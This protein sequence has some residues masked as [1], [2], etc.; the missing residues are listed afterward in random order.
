MDAP[1]VGQTVAQSK[2]WITLTVVL[3]AFLLG[4]CRPGSQPV[5][6]S[7][8]PTPTPEPRP[9]SF[10]ADELPHDVLTEWWYYTGHLKGP[11]GRA[12]GFEFVI[13]QSQRRS[14]V[15]YA[16]H[17]AITDH[18]GP[19]F[20]YAEAVSQGKQA[21]KAQLELTVGPWRLSGSQGRYS[22]EAVMQDYAVRLTT[23]PQKPPALHMGGIIDYGPAGFSY[24]YSYTRLSVSGIMVEGGRPISVR[25]TAWMDHQWGNFIPLAGGGW[26]WFA[27]QLDTGED[28]MVYVLRDPSGRPLGGYGTFIDTAGTVRSTDPRHL[29]VAPLSQWTSPRT[30]ITYPMGW[31]LNVPELDLELQLRP[32]LADQ[33]LD[34][35]KSTGVIYW[36]GEV[37]VEGLKGSVPVRGE[38]YVELTGYGR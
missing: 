18:Q 9:I 10:P 21:A 30:G 5:P 20:R 16:A 25:G 7:F 4:S 26:D 27:L 17:F 33:E 35:R 12:Y 24:Y 31:A 8:T 13:F 38:G 28:L 2:R 6:V 3:S 36:E 15:L 29:Q 32:V 19:R 34:T 11:E 14:N 23:E 22:I 1:V 37:T